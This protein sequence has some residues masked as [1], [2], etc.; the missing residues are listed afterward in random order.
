MTEH[1]R[2]KLFLERYSLSER[3]FENQK[4]ASVDL[5]YDETLTR[6]WSDRL[7]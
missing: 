3:A 2:R 1:R 4:T 6:S 5:V 7:F